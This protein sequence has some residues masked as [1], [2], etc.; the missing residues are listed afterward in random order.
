MQPIPLTPAPVETGAGL[1]FG[2]VFFSAAALFALAALV[3]F[4]LARSGKFDGSSFFAS[5]AGLIAFGLAMGGVMGFATLPFAKTSGEIQAV[6]DA[7]QEQNAAVQSTILK[8]YGLKLNTEEAG[9]LEYPEKAPKEDF[10]IYGQLQKAA[11]GSQLSVPS[12]S[13]YLIWKDGSLQLAE[14]SGQ[15][16]TELQP[17]A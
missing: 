16:F 1:I 3:L 17:K 6:V 15:D 12:D 8:N 4:F 10:K 9:A 14:G 13:V 7:A 2:I 5:L 11:E